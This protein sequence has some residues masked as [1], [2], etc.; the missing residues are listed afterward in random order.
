M[1]RLLVT[2]MATR[3]V[4]LDVVVVG[5]RHV[6]AVEKREH[7]EMVNLGGSPHIGRMVPL[8]RSDPLPA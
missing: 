3:P 1:N 6:W 8:R 4:S 5:I 2:R 7:D